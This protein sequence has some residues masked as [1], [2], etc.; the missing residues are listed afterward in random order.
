[1]FG[2]QAGGKNLDYLSFNRTQSPNNKNQHKYTLP[3][4][5]NFIVAII[6]LTSPTQKDNKA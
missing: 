1:M 5:A 6:N 2:E 4:P 3:P